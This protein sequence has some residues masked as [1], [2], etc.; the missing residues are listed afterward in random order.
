MAGILSI[1][2]ERKAEDVP[3][4]IEKAHWLY[5]NIPLEPSHAFGVVGERFGQDLQRHLAPELRVGGAVDLTHAAAA[6][7]IDDSVVGEGFPDHFAWSH[8]RL[9]LFCPGQGMLGS[10]PEQIKRPRQ[11]EVS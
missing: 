9:D 3:A 10:F 6:Q 7:L 2:V 8:D 4:Y 5:Q 1:L 11:Q